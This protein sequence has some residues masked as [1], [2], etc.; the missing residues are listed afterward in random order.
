[1]SPLIF[2]EPRIPGNGSKKLDLINVSLKMT[3]AINLFYYGNHLFSAFM[4]T[5]NISIILCYITG[6]LK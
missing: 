3:Q 5:N 6:C 2:N 4:L 1:M